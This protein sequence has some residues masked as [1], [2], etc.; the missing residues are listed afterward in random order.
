MSKSG[1]SNSDC[2]G[3]IKSTLLIVESSSI[4]KYLYGSKPD[5]TSGFKSGVS[6]KVSAAR[7]KT[8]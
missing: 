4:L 1:V 2:M 6:N 3:P 8:S 5:S 7:S